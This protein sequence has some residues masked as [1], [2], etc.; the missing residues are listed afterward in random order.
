[1]YYIASFCV[2][3]I[4]TGLEDFLPS[5][6]RDTYIKRSTLLRTRYEITWPF[7]SVS[8]WSLMPFRERPRS[9]Y[10]MTTA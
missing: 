2:V 4:K 10:F 6:V 3:D 8:L 5:P 7:P 1:M 9:C